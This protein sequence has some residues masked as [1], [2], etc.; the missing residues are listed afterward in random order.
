MSEIMEVF[1]IGA[2]CCGTSFISNSLIC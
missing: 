1:L 2:D